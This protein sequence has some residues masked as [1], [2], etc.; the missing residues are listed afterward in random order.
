MFYRDFSGGWG[1][2]VRDVS[3]KILEG[4]NGGKGLNKMYGKFF[5]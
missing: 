1:E 3:V 4:L 5:S 2:W